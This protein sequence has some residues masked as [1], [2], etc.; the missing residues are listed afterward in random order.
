MLLILTLRITSKLL[1]TIFSFIDP[2]SPRS[3]ISPDHCS[4]RFNAINI[5]MND[6]EPIEIPERNS[7]LAL[8]LNRLSSGQ[9]PIYAY[10]TADGYANPFVE[11]N[12]VIS[13]RMVN[14]SASEVDI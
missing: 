4:I 3:L 12:T 8:T 13:V 7:T 6:G 9:I 5:E 11:T 10:G 1:V 2:R 14:A